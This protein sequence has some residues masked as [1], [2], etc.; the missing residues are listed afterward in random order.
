MN[1]YTFLYRMYTDKFLIS[2]GLTIYEIKNV[3]NKFD[4]LWQKAPLSIIKNK[5]FIDIYFIHLVVA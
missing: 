4:I 5:Y 2:S 3:L 1:T